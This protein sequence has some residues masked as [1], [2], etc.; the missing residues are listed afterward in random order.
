MILVAASGQFISFWLTFN[1]S[2]S[3]TMVVPLIGGIAVTVVAR[4]Y[5]HFRGNLRPFI[6]IISG[7]LILVP[8]GIGV[9]GMSNVWSGDVSTGM[10]F[11]FNMVMIGVS[12]SIGVFLSLLPRKSW[13]KAVSKLPKLCSNATNKSGSM[14]INI[15]GDNLLIKVP[16]ISAFSN[17]EDHESESVAPFSAK[18]G[19]V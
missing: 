13:L 3:D 2:G 15:S 14:R 5:S 9:K 8:G 16:L 6:Y 10:E 18:S 4:T 12:L 19:T 11:T 7:L 17:V 1:S